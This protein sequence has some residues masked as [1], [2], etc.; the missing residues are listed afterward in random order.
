MKILFLIISII[1]A[2]TSVAQLTLEGIVGGGMNMTIQRSVDTYSEYGIS[3]QKY[4]A[5]SKVNA[6][7]GA[8]LY[9][10]DKTWSIGTS[11]NYEY[12]Y[13]ESVSDYTVATNSPNYTYNA[14]LLNF[15]VDISYIFK[16]GIGLHLGAEI[17]HFMTPRRGNVVWTPQQEVMVGAMA[18]ASYSVGRLRIELLY[19]H[20][21]NYY[22]KITIQYKPPSARETQYHTAYYRFHDIQL[23]VAYRFY[24]FKN[25]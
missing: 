6:G 8:R 17:N 3:T 4:L 14:H 21:F 18:G 13:T 10:L 25:L 16:S 15:P 22:S 9:L 7:I 12:R 1:S 11:F 24:D 20:F 2:T 5:G 23:R 19:K